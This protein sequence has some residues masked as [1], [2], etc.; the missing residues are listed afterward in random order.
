MGKY[1][2]RAR[3]LRA[4]KERHYNCA[5]A[6]LVPFAER[7]GLDE[8]TAFHIGMGFGGGMRTGSVCGAI[9]GG[10]MVLGLA[11]YDEPSDVQEFIRQM[12]EKHEG[13]TLCSDL[14]QYNAERG[15]VKREF[16]D[17]QIYDAVEI[18]EDWLDG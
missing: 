18:L 17:R 15:G 1:L 14:L 11:G 4:I 10:L 5:Q 9:T 7:F 8:E 6:V 13:M 12:Q 16:C 3:E 2:L